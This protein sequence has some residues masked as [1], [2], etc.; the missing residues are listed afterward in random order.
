MP[1]A[2]PRLETARLVLRPPQHEDF[3]RYAELRGDE[4]SCRFI[5]GAVGRNEAWRKFL[6]LAGS[7]FLQGEGPFCVLD[8]ADG[9]FL[10]YVGPWF[11]QGWPCREITYAFHPDSQ[12]RGLARE[13][14]A[15]V[16]D[17]VF[18]QRGWDA[19]HHFIDPDNTPSQRLAAYLGASIQG[20]GQLPP[21]WEMATFDIWQQ[22]RAQWLHSRQTFAQ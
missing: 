7:W 20:R 15:C 18:A 13:A 11:P 1:P 5:G 3:D 4:A 22:S 19:V 14:A 8:K 17:W 21:P 9:R 6:E 16:I 2:L 12:G 10:G